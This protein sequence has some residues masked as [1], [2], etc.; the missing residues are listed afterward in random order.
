MKTYILY[1]LYFFP[2]TG[3]KIK[4]NYVGISGALELLF[5]SLQ[6]ANFYYI[7]INSFCLFYTS[8][9]L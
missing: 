3:E 4:W 1:S 8:R 9:L 7:I 6:R 2:K 5:V